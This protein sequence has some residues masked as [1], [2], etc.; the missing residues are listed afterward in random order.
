MAETQRGLEVHISEQD[1][2]TVQELQAHGMDPSEVFRIGL[3][4]ASR[5]E[6]SRE[7]I[8]SSAL[9]AIATSTGML[10]KPSVK[11]DAQEKM[12]R[13]LDRDSSDR[14]GSK[15]DFS[16]Y[17]IK[18]WMNI[19]TYKEVMDEVSGEK[20]LSEVLRSIQETAPKVSAGI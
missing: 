13:R 10:K 4:E 11:E 9:P 3:R 7:V 15:K 19:K 2:L 6:I 14:R 12:S 16:T 20:P 1:M 5:M 17:T 8:G 18:S